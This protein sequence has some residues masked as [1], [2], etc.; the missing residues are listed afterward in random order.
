[1]QDW[2]SHLVHI[3]LASKQVANKNNWGKDYQSN[4]HLHLNLQM[5]VYTM[6]NSIII[7]PQ[8]FSK[9]PAIDRP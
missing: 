1:M 8:S 4:T 3:P 9:F 7:L 2:C 5:F 6:H